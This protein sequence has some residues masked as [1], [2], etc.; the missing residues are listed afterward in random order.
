MPVVLEGEG[1]LALWLDPEVHDEAQLSRLLAAQAEGD[2]VAFK[3]GR[4][5]GHARLDHPGL[6]VPL[7]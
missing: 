7:D 3:V 4:E 5:V 1:A 6:R 2:W